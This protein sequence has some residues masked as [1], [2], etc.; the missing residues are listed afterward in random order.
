MFARK[1][2]IEI[3]R[4][5]LLFYAC[6]DSYRRRGTHP[7]GAPKRFAKAPIVLDHGAR[8]N[9]ALRQVEDLQ[10][11]VRS[12]LRNLRKPKASA[13]HQHLSPEAATRD[14]LMRGT[15]MDTE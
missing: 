13:P 12:Y 2:Q 14:V 15:G 6:R 1:R 8:A 5:A 10:R 7:R 9:R 11:P 4:D 3:L